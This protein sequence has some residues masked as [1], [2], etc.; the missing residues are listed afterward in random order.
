MEIG[1]HLKTVKI[2]LNIFAVCM[3][4]P[5]QTILM[6]HKQI[7]NILKLHYIGIVRHMNVEGGAA[8]NINCMHTLLHHTYRAGRGSRP[9]QMSENWCYR[10][11]AT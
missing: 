10:I 4:F 1:T 6:V 8:A 7:S 3:T 2:T 11:H 5:P 9:T